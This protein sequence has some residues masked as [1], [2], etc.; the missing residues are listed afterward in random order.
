L[1]ALCLA[2]VALLVIPLPPHYVVSWLMLPFFGALIVL[3]AQQ[4]GAIASVLSWTICVWLGE[5]SYTV[6]ILHAPLWAWFAWIGQYLFGRA[7]HPAPIVFPLYLAILFAAAGLS[8]RFVERPSRRAIRAW[9]AAHEAQASTS[10]SLLLSSLLPTR[11]LVQSVL[12]AT[13]QAGTIGPAA[14]ANVVMGSRGAF[15]RARLVRGIVRRRAKAYRRHF[16]ERKG[17]LRYSRPASSDMDRILEQYLP[18]RGVFVE[19]RANDGYAVSNTYYLERVRGWRGVLIEPTPHLAWECKRERRHSQVYNC[20][21]VAPDYPDPTITLS[22][23]DVMT[24]VSE[25]VKP[26]D[27]VTVGRIARLASYIRTPPFEFSIPARTL[28]S[29][30][31]QAGVSAF[32]FLSL[33]VEGYEIPVLRGLNLRRHRAGHILVEAWDDRRLAEI[34]AH[35]TENSYRQI[36]CMGEMNRDYLYMYVADG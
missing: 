32:D 2:L 14:L 31:D 10:G 3:L 33:D 8:Y 13:T 15:M 30:L 7:M 11:G 34:D 12:Q 29:V 35:L 18:E 27:P 21:L 1:V 22:Y 26:D 19:A 5:I 24:T 6:Y 28:D 25:T 17:D 9:W 36:A 4:R 16:Y 20:A 23:G